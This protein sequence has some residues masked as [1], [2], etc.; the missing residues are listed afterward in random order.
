MNFP[1]FFRKKLLIAELVRR[2]AVVIEWPPYDKV[3]ELPFGIFFCFST[4][5]LPYFLLTK[6][7]Q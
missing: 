5:F 2:L 1:N 7:P 4:L 3:V 6:Q